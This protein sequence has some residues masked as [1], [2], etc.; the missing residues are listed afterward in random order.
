MQ[1]SISQRINFLVDH[2][3]NGIGAKFA[4]SIGFAKQSIT[5][6]S[7]P[8]LRNNKFPV[9][10][11]ELLLAICEKY[12]DVNPGWLLTGV[13]DPFLV[14]NRNSVVETDKDWKKMYFEVVTE[15]EIL[16]KKYMTLLEKVANP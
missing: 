6:L 3:S 14:S 11:T 10:S 7:N 1:H 5:R 4:T 13:G 16:A 2:Y 9:P 15:K 12:P 8:D